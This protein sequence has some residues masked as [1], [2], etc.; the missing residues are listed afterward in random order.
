[1][2]TVP[3]LSGVAGNLL[4]SVF[5]ALL[6]DRGLMTKYGNNFSTAVIGAAFGAGA[7]FATG[8]ARA[9]GFLY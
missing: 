6:E 2:L 8:C 5:G 1:M 9:Q 4:D 7:C 3:F